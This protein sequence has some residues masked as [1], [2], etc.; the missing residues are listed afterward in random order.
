MSSNNSNSSSSSAAMTSATLL[1]LIQMIQVFDEWFELYTSP[2]RTSLHPLQSKM[3][4]TLKQQ[5]KEN[6]GQTMITLADYSPTF[7]ECGF[8]PAAVINLQWRSSNFPP[9]FLTSTESCSSGILSLTSLAWY[10]R[11]ELTAQSAEKALQH[12]M[13]TGEVVGSGLSLPKS[14]PIIPTANNE[15]KSV[16]LGG[17]NNNNNSSV[18]ESAD[19]KN[20]K[21]KTNKPKWFKL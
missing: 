7:S 21:P 19:D 18:D 5:I 9:A 4:K 12:G 8:V 20:A 2:P 15:N 17:S 1:D 11:E 10:L 13:M 16:V 6:N 3:L 14:I